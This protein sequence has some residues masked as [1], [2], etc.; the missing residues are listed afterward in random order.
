MM[1]FS[2]DVYK[3]QHADTAMEKILRPDGSCNH[4]A[5]LDPLTG[6]LLA[7]SYT[8]LRVYRSGESGD[9]RAGERTSPM[10]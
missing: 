9:H 7:V 5:I 1:T 4:I 8:H 6:E 2:I 10:A 3:R